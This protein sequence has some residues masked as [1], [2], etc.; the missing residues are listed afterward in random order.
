M[1]VDGRSILSGSRGSAL[2]N[3]T[4]R[5][6]SQAADSLRTTAS[7]SRP[8]R[9]AFSRTIPSAK[10]LYVETVGR[11]RSVSPSSLVAWTGAR[12]SSAAIRS[13]SVAPACSSAGNTSSR[14]SAWR[15]PR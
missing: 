10:L 15:R 2:A 4:R 8:T 6:R 3:T 13:D 7:A 1:I 12:A 9:T 14:P 5:M 11:S